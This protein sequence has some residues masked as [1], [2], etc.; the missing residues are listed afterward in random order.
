MEPLGQMD[1]WSKCFVPACNAKVFFGGFSDGVEAA[2]LNTVGSFG[3]DPWRKCRQYA[4]PEKKPIR[5]VCTL[6]QILAVVSISKQ[7][8]LKRKPMVALFERE[9]P[10]ETAS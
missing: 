5:Q 9:L 10:Q 4:S 1:S 2:L 6:L 3:G 7:V 8:P